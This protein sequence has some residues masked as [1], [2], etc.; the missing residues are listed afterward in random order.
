MGAIA[1]GVGGADAVDALTGTPWELKAPKILGVK[2]TGQLSGWSSPKDVITTLAGILTVREVLVISWNTLVMVLKHYHVL[3]WLLFVIWVPK[4]V[5][6]PRLPI[7][8]S[9]QEI[10][11]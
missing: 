4:L 9:P 10:F 2:L 1:I 11:D 3:V 8:R 5:P 6:P 7:P